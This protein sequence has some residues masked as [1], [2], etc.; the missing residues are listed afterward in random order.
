[1]GMII[2]ILVSLGVPFRWDKF[3]GGTSFSWVGYWVDLHEFR[4][5]V[6]ATRASWVYEWLDMRP[7]S[8]FVD[9]SDLVA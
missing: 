5:G 4:L 3:R 7:Q 8:G 1:M 2:L 9:L 6:S